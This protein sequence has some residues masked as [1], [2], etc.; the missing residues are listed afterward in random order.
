MLQAGQVERTRW[1]Q[2]VSRKDTHVPL[3]Y[4]FGTVSLLCGSRQLICSEAK[5]IIGIRHQASTG[6]T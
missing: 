6:E 2:A 4:T 5:D 1:L 3:I